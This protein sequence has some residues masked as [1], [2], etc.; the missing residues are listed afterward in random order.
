[1]AQ[2]QLLPDLTEEEFSALKADI[3]ER[4]VMVPVELDEAGNVLDGHHRLLACEEL[5]VTD[6]PTIIRPGLTEDEKREHVLALNLDRR[7]LTREQRR[8]LVATLRAD[9]WSYPRIA[10]RLDVSVGTVH[11]DAQA[12][13]SENVTDTTTGQDGKQYPAHRPA[14]IMAPKREV[15]EQELQRQEQGGEAD[16]EPAEREP[17]QN[18]HSSKS[19]EWYTPPQYIA[20]AVAVMGGVD[21]D[22]ASNEEANR[23]VGAGMYYTAETDG[24]TAD[25]PG[26]VWLNPPWGGL[27]EKF[28]GRLVKQV[29]AGVTTEAVVLVNAHSTDTKWFQPLWDHTLCF[30]DHRI[31]YYGSE[32][33]GAFGSSVRSAVRGFKSGRLTVN[34]RGTL[35]YNNRTMNTKGTA[36]SN[37]AWQKHIKQAYGGSK[38]AFYRGAVKGLKP[39]EAVRQQRAFEQQYGARSSFK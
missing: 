15:A 38:D 32:G 19:N 36:P 21:V 31:N 28:I 2:Y 16:A 34:N 35:V 20:S 30:T 25:W 3:A 18:I 6:Y 13:S 17:W 33:S 29:A 1:M 4:G 23:I 10:E 22:P 9:G 37:A 26:R 27:Q 7:H 11:S 5:G 12:F 8:E 24:L 14:P 39:R